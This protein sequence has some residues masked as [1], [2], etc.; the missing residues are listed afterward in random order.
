MKDNEH[1]YFFGAILIFDDKYN[2]SARLHQIRSNGIVTIVWGHYAK[3]STT[4][5][6]KNF[7]KYLFC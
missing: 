4:D 7:R 5:F 1:T 6:A 2:L 3:K